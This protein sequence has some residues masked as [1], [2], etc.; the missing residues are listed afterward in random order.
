MAQ[1]SN[2]HKKFQFS[3]ALFGMNPFLAQ[4]VTLPDRE[5]DV[6]EHGE[7][8][9]V[10]KT[11]GMVKL[12]AM[13]VEKISN[14]SFP[15]TLLWAWIQSIQNEYAGGGLVPDSYK[16]AVQVQKYATDGIKVVQTHTFEGVWPSK[17]NGIEF[18]R[19]SSDNTIESI[20]FQVDREIII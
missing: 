15:D 4:K 5:M 19:V 20:E 8:N 16:I 14:A 18:D 6:I 9:H 10:I 13:M 12:S 7:G 2:P 3:I 11:A 17:I 1:V